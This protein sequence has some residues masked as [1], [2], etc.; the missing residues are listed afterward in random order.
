VGLLVLAGGLGQAVLT[1]AA[2]PLG[3]HRPERLA[4]AGLYRELAGLA[5]NPAPT[6]VGP[7]LGDA[8]A[9]VR[10]TLYGLGHDHGPSVEAYR[11][12][13]DEADRIRREVLVLSGLADRLRRRDQPELARAISTVLPAAAS[14]LDEVAASLEQGRPVDEAALVPLRRRLRAAVDQLDDSGLAGR[15]AAARLR[16]LAGQL[17]AAVATARAGA[18][19]GRGGDEPDLLAGV[20]RLRDP[21]AVLRANLTPGS[22]VFRHAIRAAVLVA[23]SDLVARLAGLERGYWIPL[24]V[25]VTL[26]PDFAT[27]FQRCF[28]RVVGTIIGLLLATVLVHWIPGGQWWSISLVA[29]FVFGMRLAGPGNLGLSAVSLSGLVVVLL[30]LSGVAPHTAV[31]P[32]SLDTVVGGVLAL[33]ATLIWPIWPRAQVPDRLA[34]LLERYRAYLLAV[35]DPATPGGELESTRAAA[36]LARSNAQASVDAARADPVRSTRAVDVGGAVLAH[37]HRFV[38]A[39]LTVDAVR[40]SLPPVQPGAPSRA[41]LDELLRRSAELLAV[42]ATAVRAASAPRNVAALRPLQERL[43][44]AIRADPARFGGAAVAGA[45]L[46]A[47][48]RIAN[49]LDTLVS[50][51][52]RQLGPAAPLA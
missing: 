31:L 18:S 52:R 9:Q 4:L 12:L 45:L 14:T 29:L 50:E 7:P 49:S 17:R 1:V 22:A 15:A 11:V 34:E 21:V 44:E 33:I 41:E 42:C 5:R 3:R 43:A 24:T 16:S 2:W 36:R 39:M 10:T 37:T 6:H 13:L 40:G 32:R 51:L 46:D 27:T 19:E 38:H 35:A 28:L 23:G 20:A 48:D 8:L 47:S 25:M 26:R 30:A